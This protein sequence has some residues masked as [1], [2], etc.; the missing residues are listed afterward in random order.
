MSERIERIWEN[1]L[2]FIPVKKVQSTWM[3]SCQDQW[4]GMS[5]VK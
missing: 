3:L 5:K 1:S 4:Y 2:Q